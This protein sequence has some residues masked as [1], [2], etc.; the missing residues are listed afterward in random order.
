MDFIAACESSSTPVRFTYGWTG[1]YLVLADHRIGRRLV[2]ESYN[3]AAE[4]SVQTPH[5]MIR[6]RAE[7]SPPAD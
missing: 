6:F 4:S 5:I 3:V 1:G 2:D 7:L